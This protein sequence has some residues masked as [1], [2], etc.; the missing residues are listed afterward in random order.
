MTTPEVPAGNVDPKFGI[1]YRPES[2]VR[3]ERDHPE[4]PQVGFV[5]GEAWSTRLV[6]IEH[7]V[8]SHPLARLPDGRYKGFVLTEPEKLIYTPEEWVAFY[9][10]VKG[11]EFQDMY[12][13]PT[14]ACLGDT[15]APNDHF[16][17]FTSA[18][19]RAF[20]DAITNGKY[21]LL[22]A[23]EAHILT[24]LTQPKGDGADGVSA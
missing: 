21:D 8:V 9:D 22:P 1:E 11:G 6:I 16:F 3:F 23:Q 2:V 18:G 19:F 4:G 7:T 5:Y 17:V 10:G 12:D 20:L 24:Y 15:K 13:D 14:G